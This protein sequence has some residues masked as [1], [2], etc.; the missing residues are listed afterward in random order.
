MSNNY[1]GFPAF[2]NHKFVG[3]AKQQLLLGLIFASIF[4]ENEIE[5]ILYKSTNLKL[6]PNRM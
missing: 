6:A 2:L 5:E 1:G 4:N 3:N